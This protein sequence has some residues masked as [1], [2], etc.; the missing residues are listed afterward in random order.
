[1]LRVGLTG[2]IGA[3]KSIVAKVLRSM[4]YPVFDSDSEAK[5]IMNHNPTMRSEL[6][7]I[8]GNE[9]YTEDGLNR[10]FLAQKIFNDASL[11]DRVNGLVHPAVRAAFERKALTA[12][13]GIIFNE[14]AILFE[15]GANQQF[16]AMVL[17]TAPEALRIQRVMARDNT[18]EEAVKSRIRNQWSDEKKKELAD[19]EIVN[20]QVQPLVIQ[21]EEMLEA[22]LARK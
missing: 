18:S 13:T 7:A 19:F 14:A 22:L 20:D 5:T 4:G 2:G 11:K 21:V 3:G 10:P 1:M 12:D 16:D 9:V 8:F 17:V 15:T 6:I